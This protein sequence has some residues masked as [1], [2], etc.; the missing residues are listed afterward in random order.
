VCFVYF[1]DLFLSVLCKLVF[2]YFV[3][4]IGRIQMKHPLCAILLLLTLCL[5]SFAQN[6]VQNPNFL[7]GVNAVGVPTGWFYDMAGDVE[8][9]LSV[10]QEDGF[11]CFRLERLS[12]TGKICRISANINGTKPDTEYLFSVDVKSTGRCA[13]IWIYDF[14]DDGKFILNPAK[15]N[16]DNHQWQSATYAFKTAKNSRGVKIS[17]ASTNELGGPI[18]F[19]NVTFFPA[20]QPALPVLN[21]LSSAPELK[22]DWDDPVWQ[23]AFQTSS[24][25]LLGTKKDLPAQEHLTTARYG[26]AEGALHVIFQCKE[27]KMGCR[28]KGKGTWENDGVELFLENPRTGV[29]Y[30]TIACAEGLQLDDVMNTDQIVC[31]NTDWFSTKTTLADIANLKKMSCKIAVADQQDSWTAQIRVPLDQPALK[32]IREFRLL[33]ARS[34]KIQGEPMEHST[35]GATTSTFFKDSEGFVSLTI[36]PEKYAL[37]FQEVAL[38]ADDIFQ[39]TTLVIP[40][41]QHASF[42]K[43]ALEL[44]QPVALFAPTEKAFLAAQRLIRSQLHLEIQQAKD[45]SSAQIVLLE[46]Q[47]FAGAEYDALTDWQKREAYALKLDAVPTIT[48]NTQRGFVNGIA[49]LCQLLQYD[50]Y[51]KLFYRQGELKDWPA[52]EYRGL[53]VLAPANDAEVP[54]THQLIDA[55]AALKYNWLSIQFD[56]RLK[57]EHHPEFSSQNA[58]GKDAHKEIGKHLELYDMDAIPMTQCLSHLRDTLAQP[59]LRKYAEV[60]TPDPS[61]WY[62]YWNYCPRH[63]EIHKIFFDMIEEQLECYPQAKWFHVGLDEVTF[64]TFGVCERCKNSTGGELFLEEINRLHDFVTSKGLK[65]CMWCDQLEMHNN[66]GHAP[67]FTATALPGVPR[68]IIIFDWHYEESEENPTVEFFQNE[69][70]QVMTCGWFFPQNIYP[71][72]QESHK[73]KILGYGGTTWTHITEIRQKSHLMVGLAIA[74][75]R[76]WNPTEIPLNKIPYDPCLLF[77]QVYDGRA[78]LPTVDFQ[79]IDLT[80]IYNMALKGDSNASWMGLD[81]R[82]DASALPQGIQWFKGVP[83]LV[84]GAIATQDNT[85]AMQRYPET[86]HAIPVGG[87]VLALDFLHTATRPKVVVR[88]LFDNEK[89]KPGCI[90]C[91]VIHYVD[92]SVLRIPLEWENNI[93]QWNAQTPSAFCQNAWR[94]TTKNGAQITLEKFHWQNP[95]P[96]LPIHYIDLESTRGYAAPVLLGITATTQIEIDMEL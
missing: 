33:L 77:Q 85:I 6:L 92:G 2:V 41:P 18:F 76:T 16:R 32:D 72:I 96:E 30:H 82:N 20:N 28:V 15:M 66:G 22:A 84:Q 48:A 11:K 52:M 73:R 65:M 40:T 39:P 19:K 12:K 69:G 91:Y 78:P 64:E 7:D 94:G 62:Q 43:D 54:G 45:A 34:R 53:H 61:A 75:D 35:W 25:T 50:S 37:V 49:S 44:K 47:P 57:Y 27:D 3:D 8:C 24:F 42:G 95:R 56:F 10:V 59:E 55:L 74:S 21:T 90:G 51:G 9:S 68:D 58:V 13:E 93:T 17:L 1:V 29:I 4:K 67:E 5:V 70:F 14:T 38:P 79:P 86:V 81:T 89:R 60:Q 80:G 83:F 23:N 63:P 26:Y 46:A 36:P 31:Y 88:N 87:N 71:F